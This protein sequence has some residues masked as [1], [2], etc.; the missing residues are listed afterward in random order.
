MGAIVGIVVGASFLVIIVTIISC[1]LC[2][3]CPFYKMPEPTVPA[4]QGDKVAKLDT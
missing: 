3:V 2:S 4:G 1:R